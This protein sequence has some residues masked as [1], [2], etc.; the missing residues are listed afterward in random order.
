MFSWE[1]V[2]HKDL[3]TVFI[4]SFG[5]NPLEIS[6]YVTEITFIGIIKN[7]F[8]LDWN[9]LTPDDHSCSIIYC[10]ISIKA[11]LAGNIGIISVQYKGTCLA[12]I[13]AFSA[14]SDIGSGGSNFTESFCWT[15]INTNSL[16]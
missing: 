13:W 16:K 8:A 1:G 6:F 2:N 14:L 15:V 3:E 12:T 5:I 4:A 11:G 7:S 10:Y 9:L